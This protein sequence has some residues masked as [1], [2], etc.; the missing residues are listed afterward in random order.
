MLEGPTRC[1]FVYP[2]HVDVLVK[3]DHGH[4]QQHVG[5]SMHEL[6]V[7]LGG[8]SWCNW[9]HRARH[10]L[11]IASLYW[12][13]TQTVLWLAE[14][15]VRIEQPPTPCHSASSHSLVTPSAIF[16]TWHRLHLLHHNCHKVAD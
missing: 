16:S 7:H 4:P 11:F 3:I 10:I 9:A 2:V 6:A 12:I 13:T 14:V 8:Q 15:P 5:F 1:E